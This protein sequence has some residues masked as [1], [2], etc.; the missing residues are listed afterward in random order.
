MIY[1]SIYT[2]GWVI[3]SLVMA[4]LIYKEDR[5]T[6][7]VEDW[8]DARLILGLGFFLGLFWPVIVVGFVGYKIFVGIVHLV[9]PEYKH[10]QRFKEE[11]QA[12]ENK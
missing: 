11:Q 7:K 12:S 5:E 8:W 3:A 1:F 10:E 2:V 4:R 6:E 9:F